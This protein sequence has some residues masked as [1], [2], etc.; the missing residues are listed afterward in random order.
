EEVQ[1]RHHHVVAAVAGQQ[2]GFHHF[3][4]V[5]HIVGDLDPALLFERR[6]GVFGDVIA[7][8][9]D[10]EDLAVLRGA[11]A[12]TATGGKQGGGKAEGQGAQLHGRGLHSGVGADAGLQ[13]AASLTP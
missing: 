10:V 12:T 3:V 8:V 13:T 4:T 5:E 9:V 11:V 1:R 6:D 7:V 2:L